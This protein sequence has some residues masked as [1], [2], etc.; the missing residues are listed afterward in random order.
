MSVNF[1]FCKGLRNIPTNK[2]QIFKTA[3]IN[4][5]DKC[6]EYQ[7]PTCDKCSIKFK[8]LDRYFDANIPIDYWQKNI[9][10]F[11]GDKRLL[12]IYENMNVADSFKNGSSFLFKG[13]HGV[14]KTF[15]S[16]LILKKILEKGYR[17]LY[18]TL[19]D[20]VTTIVHGP[21]SEKYEANKELKMID[22]LVVDEFDSR[23]FANDASA[24]LNGRILESIL[25]IR[26][27]NAL[28][29]I[30]IT[31]NPDPTKCLGDALGSSISSL[32]SGY[33]KEVSVIGSDFRKNKEQK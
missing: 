29:T 22:F 1:P 33:A 6:K 25:R 17:G 23:F 13:Q 20:I 10:N 24:E 32:I 16:C 19:F 5:C 31:N 4:G 27:Q 30:I 9:A 2:S 3:I 14:G 21:N 28:P 7:V 15:M 12:D 18:S 11:V 26:F 8:L